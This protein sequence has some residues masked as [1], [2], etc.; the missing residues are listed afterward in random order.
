MRCTAPVTEW[1]RPLIDSRGF[2]LVELLVVIL[3]LSMLMA[4][5]MPVLSYARAKQKKTV[6]KNDIEQL[7]LAISS[8]STETGDFPPSRLG[9]GGNGQN[10]GIESL[11][12]HLMSRDNGGPFLTELKEQQLENLDGDSLTDAALAKTL[13]WTFGDL[14]LREYVD[15]WGNPYVYFHNRDYESTQ[16][17]QLPQAK[18]IV[19]SA[20]RSA[21]TATFYSPSSYQLWSLGP[22]GANAPPSDKDNIGSW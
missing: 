9:R 18:K 8:Y 3:I 5:S 7:S 2:T 4:L 10:D 17:V 13:D 19:V 22:D 11:L 16:S 14:Q 21:K 6:C 1:R 15:V 20:G 12:A